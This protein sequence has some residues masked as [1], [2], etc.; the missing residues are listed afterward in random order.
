MSKVNA[1]KIYRGKPYQITDKISIYQPTIEDLVER[2]DDFWTVV[3]TCIGNTTMKRLVLW[4]NGR[5][6][7]KISNYQ[8]FCETIAAIPQ[9]ITSLL[10]GDID[11]MTFQ[12]YQNPNIKPDELVLQPGQQKATHTQKR[13]LKFHNYEKSHSFYSEKLD[14]ELNAAAYHQISD[15]VKQIVRIYPKNQYTVGKTSKQIIIEEQKQK[16]KKAI[17]QS[18]GKQSAVSTIQN[19]I[20]FAVNNPGYKYNIEQTFALKIGQFYDCIGRL[21]IEEQTR[22]MLQGSMSGFCDTSKIPKQNF[23]FMRPIG[24]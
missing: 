13:N 15:V 3:Y 9:Q 23:N 17:K 10:F 19:A 12:M 21:Q 24:K 14:I 18:E 1:L 4:E 7:N 6:W 5:D 2:E 8:L 16:I 22:A 11:F 20:S